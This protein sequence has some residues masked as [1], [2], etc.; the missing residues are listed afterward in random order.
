M[1]KNCEI[2]FTSFQKVTKISDENK[3]ERIIHFLKS[4]KQKFGD[5][6]NNDN[7]WYQSLL[8]SLNEAV[9]IINIIWSSLLP[10][11]DGESKFVD[12]FCNIILSD[13]QENY[14]GNW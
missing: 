1:K 10:S 4:H 8:I 5:D 7:A 12:I 13:W 6:N 11:I 3:I 9:L 14:V 2:S